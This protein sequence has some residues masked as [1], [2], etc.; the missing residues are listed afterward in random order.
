MCN[1]I[2]LDISCC[3]LRFIQIGTPS[4]NVKHIINYYSSKLDCGKKDCEKEIPRC[5]YYNYDGCHKCP[6]PEIAASRINYIC[7]FVF[8]WNIHLDKSFCKQKI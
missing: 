1:G 3:D 4:Q 2:T 7:Q 8:G 6:T 5:I